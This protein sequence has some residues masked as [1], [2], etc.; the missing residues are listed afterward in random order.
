MT[1]YIS[2]ENQ[3]LLYEMIHKNATIHQVFGSQ[4]ELKN[5]WFRSV[6]Q[7]FYNELSQNITKEE[8][9]TINRR[10]LLY[11]IQSLKEKID[12]KTAQ[13]STP[14]SNH[15]N[16]N[17]LKR[18]QPVHF[19][20]IQNKYNSEFNIPKPTTID[21]T[22]KIED[23]VITNMEEL[24]ETHK[25][26]REKELQEYTSINEAE[27]A[28]RVKI[29]HELPEDELRPTVIREKKVQFNIPPEPTY[30]LNEIEMIKTKLEN[31]NNTLMEIMELVKQNV[32]KL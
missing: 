32:T 26:I 20:T 12:T 23:T 1:L 17:T 22:E 6:I 8:L 5:T 13:P 29:L 31:I 14:I 25:K 24:I 21:F 10:T 7:S 3:H 19:E 28:T 18:E 15:E 27:N 9:K 11:M 30:L 2:T 4:T 16:Y